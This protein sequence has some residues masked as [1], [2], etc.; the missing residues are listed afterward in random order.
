LQEDIEKANAGAVAVAPGR[1]RKAVE[2][3][4]LKLRAGGTSYR[5]TS[6]IFH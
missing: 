6:L 1:L 5:E 3:Q 2:D 4:W